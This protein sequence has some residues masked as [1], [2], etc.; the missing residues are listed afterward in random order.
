MADIKK[1]AGSPDDDERGECDERGRRGHRGHRG[2]D[3]RDGATGPTGSA[4][5]TGPT[6]PTGL[7]GSTGPT[8]PT[9]PGLTIAAG[10]FDPDSGTST[11]TITRQSGQFAS[12]VYNGVGDYTLHLNVIVGLTDFLDV[13]PVGTV[14][15]DT[16]GGFII[17]AST[18]LFVDHMTIAVRITDSTGTPVDM[19][20]YI[21]AALLGV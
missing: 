11:V 7:T 6:G 17:T 16:T 19:P 1:I 14:V 13:V 3:G 4:G 9:G 2:H 10:R 8:G 18:G 21:E 20:F 12:A 15:D 5:P